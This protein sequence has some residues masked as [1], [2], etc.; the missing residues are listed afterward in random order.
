MF[1]SD[2]PI[3]KTK[4]DVLNRGIFA[5]NLA[6]A[7]LNHTAPEGFVIGMYGKWGSGKTS[8]I[9]MV[10]EQFESM[11]TKE[12]Q[13][14]VILKFNP[15]LCPDPKQLISQ[16]FKQLS[17]IFE[18]EK[19]MFKDIC[20][21]MNNYAVAFALAGI[22]TP[23]IFLPIIGNFVAQ[24][25]A[26]KN[27]DLQNIKNTIISSL[28]EKKVKLIVTIDDIDRLSSTEIASV[29]QLVKSLA[30]FPYTLYL[31][32]F[33]REIV[34]KA[35]GEVQKGYGA[36]Y[37]E[38]I[39]QIPFELPLPNADDIYQV[40]FNKLEAVT[41]G[42]PEE[43]RD[44]RYWSDLFYFGIR[45]YLH[46]IRDTVRYTNTFA[47]KY[48][49]LKD[50][51]NIID[52]IGLTCVQVFEPEVYSKLP[53]HKE[54]LCG[55]SADYGSQHQQEK[56]KVQHAYDAIISD[57]PNGEAENVKSVLRLLFPKLN[58]IFSYSSSH[59]RHYDATTAL[60]KGYISNP[61]SFERYFL[62]SLE[63][64]A[65]SNKALE[66]L[67]F[68]ATENEFLEE[69]IKINSSRKITK[70]LKYIRASFDL[71][72]GRLE[73][74]RRARMVLECLVLNWSKLDD[75]DENQAFFS[76]PFYWHL[77]FCV[78]S[79]LNTI[80]KPEHYDIIRAMFSD[81]KVDLFTVTLLLLDFEN[82]HNRF[83]DRASKDESK[84]L[85][86]LNEILELESIFV[87]RTIREIGSGEL[88]K[89]SYLIYIL[90]LLEQID[91]TK[92]KECTN[93]MINSDL[94]LAHFISSTVR[95]GKVSSR[96]VYQVW[97]VKK[98]VISKY[99]D[100]NEAYSRINTFV[101]SGE[102]ALL[103]VK[104]QENIAAF[105]ISMEKNIA[106]D[107]MVGGDRIV[108][109]DIKKKLNHIESNLSNRSLES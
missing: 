91:E 85:L 108:A 97:N 77:S 22:I 7:M 76:M 60:V 75:D 41:G 105:L 69:I 5:E 42:I 70:F 64:T 12:I 23:W 107:L 8:V 50:E 9:N 87:E 104:K 4:D 89:N 71:K 3:E 99:F 2:L 43:K 61:E 40:F 13:K 58:I 54:C 86:S 29:F 65:I 32:A 37:L 48:S 46:T 100:I 93:G 56:D 31:L 66:H 79:L 47:L 24:K 57:V 20:G 39:I 103:D 81:S 44:K 109:L 84:A 15:W 101:V 82:Q 83:T 80:D 68:T 62:L 95:L 72:K 51:T 36:E 78:H 34:I 35:L 10:L 52:L 67:L 28:L 88:I 94:D 102:F 63:P 30:D 18:K 59:S 55:S 96:T 25:A 33:D 106:H 11:A 98:D 6:K 16:F 26:K 92:A 38:K 49:L 21:Y 19:P 74:S 45:H 17:S 53:F 73:Y 1:N 14:P 90:Q 27:S